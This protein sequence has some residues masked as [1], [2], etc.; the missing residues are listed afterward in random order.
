M[1]STIKAVSFDADGTL[2]GTFADSPRGFEEFFLK[3]ALSRGKEVSITGLEAVLRRIKQEIV[4]RR[5]AGFK[6]YISEETSRQHWLWFYREVFSDLQLPDPVGMAQEFIG[7]FESGEFTSLYSDVMAC[8]KTLKSK[9][10]PMIV[11]SNYGPL[12]DEFLFKLNVKG[13]FE[14]TLISGVI[15]LEKP[16]PNLFKMGA[17]CLGL[18]PEH[19]LH[20]GN[21][22]DE[23]Y[24]G[25]QQAGFQAVLLDRDNLCQRKNIKKIASLTQI[26]TLPAAVSQSPG[27]FSNP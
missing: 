11:I 4:K 2:I 25:A 18:S 27:S 19:I 10:I 9:N 13:Y 17:H 24:Y 15:G 1:T 14:K 26:H 20:V 3:A 7:R 5:S 12:L 6:P 22:I 21:D 23:D 8:L 16:D